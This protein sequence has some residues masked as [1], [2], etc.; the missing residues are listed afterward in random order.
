M[1][2]MAQL[3]D[4]PEDAKL[5]T[6]TAEPEVTSPQIS[7]DIEAPSPRASSNR[8]HRASVARRLSGRP[9]P[10]DSSLASL[11]SLSSLT[12]IHSQSSDSAAGRTEH[13]KAHTSRQSHHANHIVSQVRHWLHQEK[14][15]ELRIKEDRMME[16][17][18]TL[19]P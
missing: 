19:M 18:K 12:K 8:Q 5:V 16:R 13:K 14:L 3:T 15:D 9:G 6:N 17:Q 4:G 11:E 7:S 10:T 2:T 1:G